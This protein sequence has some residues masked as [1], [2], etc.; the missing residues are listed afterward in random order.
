MLQALRFT[1]ELRLA[2]GVVLL[3]G[4]PLACR[5]TAPVPAAPAA[6]AESASRPASTPAVLPLAT[7]DSAWTIIER[8]HW[9]T[10]YN[11][12]DWNALRDSLRPRAAAATTQEQLRAVL[13]QM[14]GSLKQSHFSIIPSEVSD[15][16]TGGGGTAESSREGQVGL[17]TRWIDGEVV[18][19]NV[20]AG[21]SAE[22]AG[23]EPGWR[24]RVVGDDSITALVQ[25]LPDDMD[26]RRVALA[27]YSLTENGLRGA[28]GSTVAASFLDNGDKE[29]VLTLERAALKGA[30][31]KFGN[32]PPQLARLE[33]ERRQVDGKRIGVIRFNIWM[34]VLVREFDVAI[35]SLRDSDA[36]VLDIRGNFG[37]VAGMSMG[38]AGHFVDT[39]VPVGI[40]KTRA[41]ELKFAINPRRVNTANQRV[42]PFA[43]PLAIVVDELSISTSEIF[44]G[45][46]QSLSRARIVGSQTA[47]QALPAVAER[48]PNGDIL[49]HAIANFLSPSGAS[50][51][52]D[53]VLPDERAVPTRVGLQAG[54]DEALE[55]ALRWAA[56]APSPPPVTGPRIT[57]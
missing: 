29:R 46:M 22:R 57:P 37:G 1:A 56:H 41:Q 8:T 14:V 28:I 23:V 44:A 49:Y 54:R 33:W 3:F 15:V 40:M 13:R 18:V 43:G 17:T 38:M 30:M 34:P 50:M 12:V 48:L 25:S 31:V 2:A 24:L 51:E 52:G 32:L 36:I 20:E 53:G 27:A 26:V 21:S 10:A 16:A 47:G 42:T 55:A 35:D 39:V 45:G 9:D 7:F 4:G 11:G 19:T 6:Q 5:A